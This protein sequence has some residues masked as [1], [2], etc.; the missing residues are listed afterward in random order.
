VKGQGQRTLRDWWGEHHPP[1]LIGVLSGLLVAMAL[2]M[3]TPAKADPVPDCVLPALA[4]HAARLSP[5]QHALAVVAMDCATDETAASRLWSAHQKAE[6]IEGIVPVP[7][8]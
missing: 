1:I 4:H 3:P 2:A 8:E 7:V 6:R 5:W